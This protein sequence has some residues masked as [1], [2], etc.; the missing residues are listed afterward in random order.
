MVFGVGQNPQIDLNVESAHT[1]HAPER[2]KDIGFGDLAFG[3]GN[4]DT[5][6]LATNRY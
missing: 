5:Q 4:P 1:F 3:A 2:R 6:S